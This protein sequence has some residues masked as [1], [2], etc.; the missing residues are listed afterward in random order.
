[1]YARRQFGVAVLGV[2]ALPLLFAVTGRAD[3]GMVTALVPAYFPPG[4]DWDRLDQAAGK[5]PLDAIMNPA[6]GPGTS[7]DPNYVTAVSKLQA[8]GG[9]V[10]GYVPTQFGARP[11]SAVESDISFYVNNYHVNGIFLDQVSVGGGGSHDYYAALY[12]YIKNISPTPSVID[13][14]GAPFPPADQFVDVADTLVTFEGPLTNPDP[15]G[16]SFQAYPNSGPYAGL[17]P[18]FLKQPASK[19]ANVVFDVPTA[20]DMRSALNKAV[21]NNAGYVYFTDQTLPNPY[22]TLPSYWDQEV[23]A[24]AAANAAPEPASLTLLGVGALGLLGYG[25]RRRRQAAA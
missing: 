21:Q 25:W 13:N 4:P 8:A 3:A 1:M 11:L 7:V 6:S 24:I 15:N 5:V 12:Q 16:P 10:L 23:A 19:I 14:P 9:K 22:G 17:S 18:W 2:V 20:G